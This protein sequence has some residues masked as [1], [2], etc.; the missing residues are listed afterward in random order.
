MCKDRV[1]SRQ[2]TLL[3]SFSIQK[4]WN[5]L[6]QFKGQDTTTTEILP[7]ADFMSGVLPQQTDACCWQGHVLSHFCLDPWGRIQA[8]QGGQS[9]HLHHTPS[10]S[11]TVFSL[12]NMLWWIYMLRWS[13]L[14]EFVCSQNVL[15]HKQVSFFWE[16]GLLDQIKQ[17]ENGY[18]ISVF[19]NSFSSRCCTESHRF[20]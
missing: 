8:P 4:M 10:Y 16:A 18:P 6:S 3:H 14:P 20:N 17:H 19:L 5:Q 11:A 7:L 13:F 1:G 12:I 2:Q 9:L 15:V